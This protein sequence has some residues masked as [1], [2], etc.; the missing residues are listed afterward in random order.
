MRETHL[1][2]FTFSLQYVNVNEGGEDYGVH[3]N[4]YEALVVLAAFPN[5]SIRVE[6]CNEG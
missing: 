4:L 5:D 2:T 1:S 3:D 6:V